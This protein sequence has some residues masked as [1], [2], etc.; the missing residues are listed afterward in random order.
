MM[1]ELFSGRACSLLGVRAEDGGQARPLNVILAILLLC[2][3]TVVAAENNTLTPDDVTDGWILLFDGETLFGWEPA[4]KA[5]W[6][7]ADGAI[8]V[9]EGEPGLLTTTSPFG[10]YIF[11]ADFRHPAET[12]S[13]IFLRTPPKPTDAAGDCYELNIAT[14]TVS[15]F[16]TGSFVK[17]QKA[18]V[19]AYSDDWHTFEVTADGGHF[20]VKL[21]GQQVLDYTDPKPIAQGRIGLQFN[22][23]RV[24][25][26]NIKL[27]PLGLEP[28]FNG[29]DL[30]GWKVYPDKKSTFEVADGAIRVTNGPGALESE[31]QFGNFVLQ[32]E[33]F[34]NG[35]GLNSGVF[36]RAIPGEY[37]NGYESQIHNLFRDND[38]TQPVDGG[39]GGIYRR[40]KARRVVSDDFGWFTKTIVAAGPHI[41][42]WVNGYQ[43]TDWTDNRPPDA[44]PRKG[45]RVEAGTLQLQGHDP[46]T[47]VR[48]R[49]LRAREQ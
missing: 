6:A 15:P 17:R 1:R 10:N 29:K 37:T 47:D 8:S 20:V 31:S 34:T 44:N 12:N 49:N 25:F 19:S 22:K 21:D 48:F 30:S 18:T 27:K 35:K 13:G 39:T 33:A 42:V 23:G 11:K 28:L 7:V 32:L 38:R 41:G 5:N 46:T 43:V 16:P 24:E 4:T 2:C 9:S 14:E 26:R 45:L 36:F 40:I 3:T